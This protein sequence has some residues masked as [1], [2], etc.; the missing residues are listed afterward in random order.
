[1]LESLQ[2]PARALFGDADACRFE[3]ATEEVA[4]RLHELDMFVLPSLSE[5]L[6]N[7]LMERGLADAR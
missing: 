4:R 2:N 5:A 3:P 7:S 1:L 6:S